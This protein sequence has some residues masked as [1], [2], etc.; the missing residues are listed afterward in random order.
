VE[1]KIVIIGAGHVG[2][3]VALSLAY[4]NIA[5]EIVFI[6]IIEEKARAQAQEVMDAA[7]FAGWPVTARAGGYKDCAGAG[8]VFLCFG[9]PR[10]PGMTRLDTFGSSIEASLEV[11]PLL[12][13][14]DT[15]SSVIISITN[16]ADVV[17][18]FFVQR[19]SLEKGQLFSTGTLL[20][21]ARMKQVVAGYF[22]VSASS[23]DGLVMG[24][25]GD[26]QFVPFSSLMVGSKPFTAMF[27]NNS[28]A[29]Y[30]AS[31]IEMETAQRGTAIMEGKGST[32]FG[33]G[34]VAAMAAKAVLDGAKRVLPVS[35]LLEGEYGQD[36]FLIGVPAIIGASGV[37]KVVEL[38]LNDGELAR[39]AMSCAVVKSYN[40][41]AG[42][43]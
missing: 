2:S 41:M 23:I 11:L 38:P 39:F 37:Q 6:D 1:R 16:P 12:A 19:L 30:A 4:G 14:A 32:E 34:Y 42:G 7:A 29:A 26:S 3:H 5:N 35:T 27:S 43:M 20:D 33:I 31:Q 8:V 15:Q 40:E 36:G 25:H 22:D 18:S 17:A 13:R 28:D 21:T 24:E 10:E 9:K